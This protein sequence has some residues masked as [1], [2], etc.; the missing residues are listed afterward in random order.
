MVNI[1]RKIP[2]KES[3]YSYFYLNT[4]A[5]INHDFNNGK[6]CHYRHI[7]FL[8]HYSSSDHILSNHDKDTGYDSIRV[9]NA[10]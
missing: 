7:I 9:Q 2:Y 10:G 4:A 1:F 5:C 6:L 3:N 8:L